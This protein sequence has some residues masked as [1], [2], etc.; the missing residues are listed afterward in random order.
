MTS[1]KSLRR[2]LIA[3][4]SYSIVVKALVEEGQKMVAMP[5]V[6]SLLETAFATWSVISW[7]SALPSV[8]RET[9]VVFTVIFVLPSLRDAAI[10]SSTLPDPLCADHRGRFRDVCRQ[11]P[12]NHDSHFQTRKHA[13]APRWQVRWHKGQYASP[14]RRGLLRSVPAVPSRAQANLPFS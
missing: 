6:N 3:P 14:G 1:S 8:L 10:Q 7:I 9:D 11:L 12:R 13:S 5:A 2:S 4:L